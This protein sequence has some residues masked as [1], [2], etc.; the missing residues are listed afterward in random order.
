YVDSLLITVD[1]LNPSN[2]DPGNVFSWTAG[3]GGSIYGANDSQSIWIR[4]SGNFTVTV[5]DSVA[6]VCTRS[7][8]ATVNVNMRPRIIDIL[9]PD[10]A[11]CAGAE[12]SIR[13]NGSD[14]YS[15]IWRPSL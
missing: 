15:Y 1:V 6:G 2:N 10:T 11:V 13:A 8:T 5:L 12:V 7:A 9:T 4:P 3:G 14:G